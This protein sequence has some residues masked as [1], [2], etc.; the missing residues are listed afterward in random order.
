[1]SKSR[2]PPADATTADALGRAKTEMPRTSEARVDLFT[3]GEVLN[4][5]FEIRNVL[6]AGGMGQVFEAQDRALNRRVAIKA[7]WP[8]VPAIT[9]RREA[10]A[11]AAIRHPSMITV[12]GLGR[13]RG[14]EYVVMERVYGVS[15]D[16]HM[17]KRVRSQVPFSIAETLDIL[18]GIAEG[19][20]AV[21][22]AGV[23]HRDIKPENVM[24]AP[25]NR[26]ILMD[27]GIVM[28]EIDAAKSGTMSGSPGYMAP[29]TITDGVQRGGAFLV[30]MYALGVIGFEL[31]VGEL[32]YDGDTIAE[33]LSAHVHDPVPD[34][35]LLRD[36][37]PPKL[38]RLI[39]DLM[40]KD[41]TERPPTMETVAFQLRSLAK[42][43]TPPMPIHAPRASDTPKPWSVLVVD[44]DKEIARLLGFYVK[45][46]AP[47]AEVR[48]C[49]EPEA[50][51]D[52]MTKKAP[53]L[54]LLDLHMPKMNGIEVC[55]YV[56]GTAFADRVTIVSVS[57][58]AQEH[59]I[60]LLQ[61]LGIRHFV[62]KDE[63][64]GRRIASLVK[65][66]R[67]PT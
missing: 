52:E 7:A 21:H 22:R 35:G 42:A 24:I 48:I 34:P 33:I 44:D 46:V 40:A 54:L 5:T 32:P 56:R 10:Q 59:D 37:C 27:F 17:D 66:L 57:A 9:L 62:R 18:A 20:S 31:L 63:D 51:L 50:A 67:P 2:S 61:Q 11:V 49:N 65:E 39:C 30:D 3:V 26:I 15:L 23:A 14:V 55:M 12:Y 13:H 1:M 64:L 16:Q 58:G 36:D 6:G 60:S 53:D 4:D 41:P 8:H 19:L 25:G 28:P 29:E 47:D 45:K 38:A 43:P